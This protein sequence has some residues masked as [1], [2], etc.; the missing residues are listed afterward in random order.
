MPSI[1]KIIIYS[2]VA[3]VALFVVVKV[4]K[5]AHPAWTRHRLKSAVA[6]MEPWT[7]STNYTDAAWKQAI[8]AA[9]AYQK[10]D[11]VVV[12]EALTGYLEEFAN[13]PEQQQLT[14][15]QSKAYLLLRVIF[16]VPENGA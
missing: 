15:A 12:T 2:V 7:A 14:D 10:A 16:D 4:F 5:M 11:R 6:K 8:K 3:L 1:K 13:K 9:K